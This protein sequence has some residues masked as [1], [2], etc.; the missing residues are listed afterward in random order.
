MK[1]INMYHK[2]NKK[3]VHKNTKLVIYNPIYLLVFTYGA[4]SCTMTTRIKCY[5]GGVNATN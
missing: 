5:K 2:I 3:E 1:T 4:A